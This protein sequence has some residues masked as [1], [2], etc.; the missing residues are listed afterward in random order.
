MGYIYKITNIHNKKAYIGQS[1]QLDINSRWGGHIRSINTEYGCPLLKSA[2][3]KYGIDNFRF[4]IIIICFDS[5]RFKYEK[6]YIKKYNTL[7]PYG[8]NLTE[9]GEPGGNFKG[10]VHRDD[11]KRTIVEKT[12]ECVKNPNNISKIRE[13][14]KK[15]LAKSEKWRKAKEEGR[16]G[17]HEYNRQPKSDEVKEKLSKSLKEFY[18]INKNS[19][20]LKNRKK[21]IVGRNISQYTNKNIF[22]NTFISIAD[23]ARQTGLTRRNIQANLSG[24]NKTAGGFIWKYN[25]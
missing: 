8:Y 4:D 3:K 17:T 6:E 19:T 15:G 1:Q 5:D 14:V 7:A 13:G 18:E 9:G 20:L 23:A 16:V 25:D 21:R 2:F 24:R 22:I 12:T 11:V 10:K